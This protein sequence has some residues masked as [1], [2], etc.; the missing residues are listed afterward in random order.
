MPIVVVCPGC[1]AKLNAPDAA[2]GKRVKC[3][4]PDC[5]TA[6]PVPA[7]LPEPA[8]PPPP[9]VPK[10]AALDLDDEDEAPKKPTKKPARA[11]DEDDE[12][13]DDRPRKK[14]KKRSYDEDDEDDEDDDRPK[15]KKKKGGM[16]P[17]LIGV[18]ALVGLLVLGGVGYGVYALAFKKKDDTAGPGGST[19]PAADPLAGWTEH[20]SDRD[21]FTIRVP[22]QMMMRTVGGGAR[23]YKNPPPNPQVTVLVTD[24][25]PNMPPG[26][27]LRKTMETGT[28]QQYKNNSAVFKNMTEKQIQYKGQSITEVSFESPDGIAEKS[29]VAVRIVGFDKFVY[30]IIVGGTS[31]FM[32]NADAVFD[33]FQYLK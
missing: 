13:E 2:A 28:I 29:R 22:R 23:E 24:V 20:R 4:K 19:T 25:K 15:K 18:L 32:A 12:D 1:G 11:V 8:P 6:V 31:D 21:K 10:S 3:P 33:S 16:S 26:F 27:D 7:V 17:A 14:A 9:P 5:G 30:L